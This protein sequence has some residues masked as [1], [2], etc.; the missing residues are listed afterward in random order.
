M[1]NDAL[2][3]KEFLNITSFIEVTNF[4]IDKFKLD[5]DNLYDSSL[6]NK[7]IIPHMMLEKYGVLKITTEKQEDTSLVKRL[8]VKQLKLIENKDYIC[9]KMSFKTSSGT[10]YKNQYFLS[11]NSFKL[12]LMRSQKTIEYAKHFIQI[13]NLFFLYYKYQ[14]EYE[15]LKYKNE[16]EKLKNMQHI[17]QYSREKAIE[18]LEVKVKDKYKIECVY[19]IQEEDFDIFKVG[20][21]DNLKERLGT[22]QVGNSRNLHMYRTILCQSASFYESFVHKKI[23][24]YHIRGEWYELSKTYIDNLIL[25]IN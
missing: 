4:K 13:E 25:S 19:F 7:C 14:C 8:L 3:N 23:E 6:E 18:R 9:T 15:K 16:I 24:K 17:K 22:L 12:C 2:L 5:I 1:L 20:Y 10:K 21:T 11:L